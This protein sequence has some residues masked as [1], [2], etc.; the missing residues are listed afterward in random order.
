MN[1]EKHIE[2]LQEMG[3]TIITNE[4]VEELQEKLMKRGYMTRLVNADRDYLIH[5][6]K[7]EC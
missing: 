6:N 3:K 1:I 4:N 7:K 5:I 2:F